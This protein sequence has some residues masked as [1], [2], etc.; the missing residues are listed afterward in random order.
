MTPELVIFDCDG[1][2]V[3]S[4]PLAARVLCEALLEL[5]LEMSVDQVDQLFRGRSLP[6]IVLAVEAL[7]RVQGLL[8]GKVPEAFLP[9]LRAETERAFDTGL[10][11]IPGVQ[12]AL[13]YLAERG[14]DMCVAS[15]GSPEKIRHSLRLT[16]LASFFEDRVFSAVQV[17]RGKPAPDLFLFAARQMGHPIT[18][19][20]V[21][22]DSLPGVTGA[23]AAG[24]SVLGFVPPSLSDPVKQERELEKLGA[25]V[26]RSMTDL[27]GLLSRFPEF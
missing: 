18:S 4:E 8:D 9:R 25:R 1:V 26:F 12:A 16:D 5:G 13:F 2:L 21:I 19:S 10:S 23:L 22:E 20:V 17:D 6:D 27:P 15:S 14:V 24:A 11:P 3:D 7:L